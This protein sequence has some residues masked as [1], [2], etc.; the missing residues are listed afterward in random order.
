MAY[1]ERFSPAIIHFKG[2]EGIDSFVEE[3]CKVA[4]MKWN[5]QEVPY[6]IQFMFCSSTF[7]SDQRKEI[8]RKH[9]LGRVENCEM[10]SVQKKKS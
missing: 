4:E 3:I 2:M 10:E 9:W 1:D 7:K 8:V 5:C 6:Q